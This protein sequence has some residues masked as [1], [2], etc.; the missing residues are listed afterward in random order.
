MAIESFEINWNALNNFSQIDYNMTNITSQE[1]M[2]RVP[3][4]ANTMTN[5]YYGI[6]VLVILAV[7]LYWIYTDKTQ[8]GN[9]RYSE[10]RGLGLSLG[11]STIMGLNMLSIGLIT[12]VIHLTALFLTFLITWG[13]TY[14]KNPS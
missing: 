8:F 13:Y 9:F 12:N 4:T 3:E 10:V 11:V 7:F 5:G 1:L 2:N 14:I 6:I